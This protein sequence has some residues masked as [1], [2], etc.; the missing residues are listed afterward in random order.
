MV[1]E[2]ETGAGT[3]TPS[4]NGEGRFEPMHSLEPGG[5]RAGATSKTAPGWLGVGGDV[6]A[7]PLLPGT[8]LAWLGA[9]GP[10]G[11]GSGPRCSLHPL[12]QHQKVQQKG[13]EGW[14]RGEGP[15]AFLW[16]KRKK[17]PYD[18]REKVWMDAGSPALGAVRA[19]M[20]RGLRGGLGA[21]NAAEAPT[22]PSVLPRGRAATRRL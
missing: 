5:C 7:P 22:H 19:A 21:Q 18:G 14:E 17:K 10:I 13:T 15:P 3:K 6:W 4:L 9:P 20:G 12:Q 8:P 16:I 1:K 2:K 11:L